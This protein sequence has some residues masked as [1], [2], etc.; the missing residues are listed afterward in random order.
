MLDDN[1]FLILSI[2]YSRRNPFIRTSLVF[3]VTFEDGTIDMPY[4]NDLATSTP[5][6]DYVSAVPEL[7]PLQY[8]AKRVKSELAQLNRLSI[9]HLT[10]GDTFYLSLRYFDGTSAS[11]YDSLLLPHPHSAYVFLAKAISWTHVRQLRLR[12]YI[13]ALDKTYVLT[14]SELQMFG[15]R[16]I[17]ESNSMVLLTII[18]QPQFPR[19]WSELV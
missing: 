11:W 9:T 1:Q 5:F 4:N 18:D 16:R 17:F 8:P 7:L 14:N 10:L 12:C 6:V 2:N 15:S 19:I 13:A 3:N